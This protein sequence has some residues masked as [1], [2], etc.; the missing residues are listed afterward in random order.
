MDSFSSR[1]ATDNA[2]I[3]KFIFKRFVTE[4]IFKNNLN[5][6]SVEYLQVE[7]VFIVNYHL[8]GHLKIIFQLTNCFRTLRYR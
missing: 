5:T 8:W 1:R 3:Q 2:F 7:F 6:Q 4:L